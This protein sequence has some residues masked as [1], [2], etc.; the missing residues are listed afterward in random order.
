MKNS[1][2]HGNQN[3]KPI[4][5][6]PMVLSKMNLQ[7]FYISPK[8]ITFGKLLT[9]QYELPPFGALSNIIAKMHNTYEIL[10]NL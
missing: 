5:I 8:E 7:R 6:S 1:G 10:G 2:C 4:K 3:I 9:S